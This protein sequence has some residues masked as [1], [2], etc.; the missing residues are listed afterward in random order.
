[1]KERLVRLKEIDFPMDIAEN[2]EIGI[3]GF[4]KLTM[5]LK[6]MEYVYTHHVRY[7][8]LD[9]TGHMTNLK[10]VDLFLN[11]FDSKFFEKFQIEA[12]ELHF[13]NQCFEGETIHVYKKIS[14]GKI[15]LLAVHDSKEP[16]AVAVVL[17][18]FDTH[19]AA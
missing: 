12:F 15:S 16:C 6:E 8:D 1:M 10:Y 4:E 17:G 18:E 5:D 3:H 9:K 2:I 19:D 14:D 11:A 13:L 7:T